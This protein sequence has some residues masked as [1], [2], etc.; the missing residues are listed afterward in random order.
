MQQHPAKETITT[1]VLKP[2][3]FLYLDY[4]KLRRELQ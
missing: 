2:E 1:F 3:I 4:I